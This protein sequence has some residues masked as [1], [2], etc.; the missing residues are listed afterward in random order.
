MRI[1]VSV[2]DGPA[3]R[4]WAYAYRGP[5]EEL[6]ERIEGGN[7]VAFSRGRDRDAGR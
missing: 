4:A 3:E 1:E 5:A 7:W 2:A 6:G